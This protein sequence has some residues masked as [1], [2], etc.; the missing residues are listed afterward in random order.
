V[1]IILSTWE[2]KVRSSKV[3]YKILSQKRKQAS[4]QTKSTKA[5]EVILLQGQ[6]R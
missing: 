3:Q 2:A 1:L 5:R 4:K 6:Y